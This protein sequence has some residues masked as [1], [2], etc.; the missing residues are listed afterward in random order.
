MMNVENSV[1]SNTAELIKHVI[2]VKNEEKNKAE[3]TLRKR[4]QRRKL[5]EL[6]ARKRDSQLE[7]LSLEE[8]IAMRESA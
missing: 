6:I 1:E 4:E 2:D 5:D 7:E 3:E 8:L